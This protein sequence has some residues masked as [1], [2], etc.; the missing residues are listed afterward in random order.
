VLCANNRQ[1]T[2]NDKKRIA[3]GNSRDRKRNAPGNFRP[4]MSTSAP[5]EK[6]RHRLCYSISKAKLHPCSFALSAAAGT[7]SRLAS[8]N[9]SHFGATSLSHIPIP[10]KNNDNFYLELELDVQSTLR[11]CRSARAACRQDRSA[12]RT[13]RAVL[14]N[15]KLLSAYRGFP[16]ATR[17]DIDAHFVCC[18]AAK[19]CCNPPTKADHAL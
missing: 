3:P 11:P 2:H 9:A 1:T 10:D 16:L 6:R 14:K 12:S 18:A 13:P 15:S 7:R 8:R 4:T 5:L 17:R 19:R